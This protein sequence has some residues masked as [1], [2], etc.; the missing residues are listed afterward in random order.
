MQPHQ[1]A[2]FHVRRLINASLPVAIIFIIIYKEDMSDL[3]KKNKTSTLLV[4]SLGLVV[5][6]S[7]ATLVI[8]S[9]LYVNSQKLDLF[10][11]TVS[12]DYVEITASD[13]APQNNNDIAGNAGAGSAESN[14][15]DPSLFDLAGEPFKGDVNAPVTIVEFSDYECPFCAR[16]AL[17]TYPQI[18]DEYIDKGLVR[19]VYKDYPLTNIHPQAV[20]AAVAANC[21]ADNLSNEEYFEFHDI[22]Y[23][24]QAALSANTIRDWALEVGLSDAQYDACIADS[25]YSDE[26][27]GD[28]DEG[29]AFGVT[30]TPTLFINGEI[31]VGAQ[32]FVTVKRMIDNALENGG[33]CSS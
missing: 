16:F 17:E 19:L 11:R 25:S 4:L 21:I 18:V 27:Y 20:P 28:F 26:V 8:G 32:P 5:G 9:L 1:I 15:V 31:V 2:H 6:L 7:I 33:A 30:G 24:R 3:N 29:T 10:Y 13:A 14:C 23:S 22:V 12:P